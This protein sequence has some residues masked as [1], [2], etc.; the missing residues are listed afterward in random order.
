MSSTRSTGS[1]VRL[2]PS[3]PNAGGCMT[4]RRSYTRHGLNAPCPHQTKRIQRDRPPNGGGARALSLRRELANAVGG[5]FSTLP[6]GPEADRPD[7][8]EPLA[9]P[10][11]RGCLAVPAARLVNARAKTLLPILVQRQALADH[12]T[13]PPDRLPV[14]P[15]APSVGRAVIYIPDNGRDPLLRRTTNGQDPAHRSPEL[16]RRRKSAPSRF[17]PATL[18]QLT[19]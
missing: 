12:L 4:A 9:A 1:S 18:T 10:R 11:P 19:A 6:P 14:M 15:A 3:L 16:N 2:P 8:E 7:G 17:C 13:S 5:G